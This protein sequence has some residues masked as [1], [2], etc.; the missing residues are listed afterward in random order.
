MASNEESP[1]AG[2]DHP[3]SRQLQCFLRGELP[4]R[5]AREIV[6]H[7]LTG[8]PQCRQVTRRLWKNP[9]DLAPDPELQERAA[10]GSSKPL[11][12]WRD[13]RM[14]EAEAAAQEELREIANVLSVLCVRLES[15]HDRLPVPLQETAMLLGEE[16]K[17][18]ATEIRSVVECIL[19]DSLRPT[20][21]DLDKA[22][23]YRPK[24]GEGA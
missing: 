7:L 24:G 1:P 17:D 20:I 5:E 13:R 23:S 16:E 18:V 2:S 9:R 12:R 14:T 11:L 3:E 22:A 4:R 8:C 15:I 10:C 21:R 19:H 6:R